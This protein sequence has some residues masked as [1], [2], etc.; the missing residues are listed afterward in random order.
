[1]IR[2]PIDEKYQKREEERAE[3][4]GKEYLAIRLM[5]LALRRLEKPKRRNAKNKHYC[6]HQKRSS[7]HCHGLSQSSII[8]RSLPTGDQV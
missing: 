5:G 2:Q 7:D 6:C 8:F 1:M 3:Q 4:E